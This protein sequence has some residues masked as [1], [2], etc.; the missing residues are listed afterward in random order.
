MKLAQMEVTQFLDL[1]STDAPA[2]GGGSVSALAGAQGTALSLMVVNLT[3]GREKYAEFFPICEDVLKK[4]EALLKAFIEAI[5]NDTL[6]FNEVTAAYKMPKDTDEQK[7]ERSK[8]IAAAT[9]KATEVPF[10]SM[11]L[12]EEALIIT[13]KLV[14]NSNPNVSSDLGVAALSLKS[15]LLGSWL[16]VKINL[17]SIKDADKKALFE[18]EGR[19]MVE[20]SSAIADEI[21]EAVLA[22]F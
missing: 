2:P 3:F 14:G 22:T 5:D 8:A 19:A 6:A 17:P 10:E 11:K 7:K 13:K 15:A 20:R 1:L 18:K 16:N 21:Y 12:S 9:L 4:G